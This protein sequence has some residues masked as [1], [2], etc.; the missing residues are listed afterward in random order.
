M[1][2]KKEEILKNKFFLDAFSGDK[3]IDFSICIEIYQEK[4]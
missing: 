4:Y 2:R 1:K 3:N